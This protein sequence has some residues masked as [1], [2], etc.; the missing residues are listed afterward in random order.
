MSSK[1][2][3]CFCET[4]L[5]Q[6][7][8]F[9]DSGNQFFDYKTA[10]CNPLSEY[11]EKTDSLNLDKLAQLRKT[12]FE[13]LK[14]RAKSKFITVGF[15]YDLIN[16]HSPLEKSYWNTIHCVEN[17]F[18][19]PENNKITG[20]Y[21]NNRWCLVCNRIRTAKLLNGYMGEISKFQD[22]TFLTLTIPNVQDNV[23]EDSIKEMAR[24][25]REILNNVARKQKIKIDGIRKIECTYNLTRNDF[26]PHYHVLI[27]GREKAE[28]MQREW[29][30]RYPDANIKAQDI[31]PADDNSIKELFKY[32]TKIVSKTD[33]N[34][35]NEYPVLIEPLDKINI[36][37]YGKRV[38]QSF[39]KVKKQSEEVEE[40]Q[41]EDI[42]SIL[43][44]N[45]WEWV[46]DQS[47]WVSEYGECLTDNDYHK[48]LKVIPK[49][50]NNGKFERVEQFEETR[51]KVLSYQ[52][53]K[54][55][56]RFEL[57]NL[58]PEIINET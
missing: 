32:F 39:G 2:A 7:T 37:F 49:R 44:G 54:S 35:K 46:Q 13:K 30:K 4:N 8:E 47:D 43:E 18:Y 25:F 52:M 16:I 17:L 56:K 27:D 53:K 33:R 29:L 3:P 38:F 58:R 21:C 40:I 24:N 36:A 22:K 19:N 31:R 50:K 23:L 1:I 11:P 9:D 41:A 45:I 14:K 34:S 10:E 57:F 20:K 51:Q 15:I 55:S 26:H 48:K 28:F 6:K 12:V 42:G 5:S